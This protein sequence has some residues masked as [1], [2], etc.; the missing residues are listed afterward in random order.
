[1]KKVLF[2]LTWLPF[3]AASCD[4]PRDCNDPKCLSSSIS[5]KLKANLSDSART[6]RAGET[7]KMY[8]KIPDT[9]ITSEGPFYLGSVQNAGLAIFYASSN[10]FGD[11][12]KV[13]DIPPIIV[14]KGVNMQGNRT[15]KLKDNRELELFFIFP[16]KSNY[17]ISLSPQ[18]QRLEITDRNG[19]KYL[20][21]LDV[22]FNVKD[23]HKD[24]YLSWLPYNKSQ[25]EEGFRDFDQRGLGYFC[26]KVE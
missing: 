4:P 3:I 1:M 10:A 24:L 23:G 19:D 9:L 6:F 15:F 17:Y 11:S 21:M 14:S 7:L 20:I 26:F 22:G 2:L 12:T 18:S 13:P 16:K 25:A 5:L 8:L